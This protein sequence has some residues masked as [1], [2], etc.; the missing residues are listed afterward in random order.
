MRIR[1][2]LIKLLI[3]LLLLSPFAFLYWQMN[4]NTSAISDE[5]SPALVLPTTFT[6][7][8]PTL[9]PVPEMA[10]K[11]DVFALFIV[12]AYDK[13]MQIHWK[14]HSEGEMAD[15]FLAGYKKQISTTTKT[16]RIA[17]HD[18][19]GFIQFLINDFIPR[20]DADKR[21]IAVGVVTHVLAQLDPIGRNQLMSEREEVVL[22]QT[23]SNI[24]PNKDL[25]ADIGVPKDATPEVIVEKYEAQ[26]A[27]LEASSSPAAKEELIEVTYAKNVLTN[28]ETKA[29]Y[30]TKLIL[31]TVFSHEVGEDLLYLAISKISPTTMDEFR[32]AI[33]RASTTPTL[34]HLVIDLRQNIGGALDFPLSF[35]GAYVGKGMGVLELSHQNATRTEE[36]LTLAMPELSRYTKQIVITDRGTQSTAEVVAAYFKKK[37]LAVL[38]GEKTAGW[39]TVENTFPMQTVIDP[40]VKY[41]LFLVHSLTLADDGKPIQG[42]GV[43]PTIDVTTLGWEDKLQNSF[44]E[45]RLI[46][47]LRGIMLL[48]PERS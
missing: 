8:Q 10:E 9:T 31:P 43:A 1:D 16:I 33:M 13:I 48:P 35:F 42:R 2:T 32:E 18:R 24:N 34:N 41:T 23:V 21:R 47:T 17:P 28:K 27:E 6:L 39:G 11:P 29:R 26:K 30:D 38:I 3:T 14:V 36:T 19:I 7:A 12:E 4:N 25:Y 37:K 22:R 46:E 5:L 15:L 40:S 45:S 20:N 44:G